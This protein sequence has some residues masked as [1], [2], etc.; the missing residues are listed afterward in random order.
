MNPLQMFL[1][2][3]WVG[4]VVIVILT[5][6][7]IYS[8]AVMID[9]FRSYRAA[10]DE[11]LQFLPLF[12]KNLRDSNFQGALDAARKY[13]PA[14]QNGRPVAIYFTIRVDFRLR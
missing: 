11:S 2:A 1:D 5:G 9:K 7:S 8:I 12:V 10:R 6:L 13:K 3:S 4:K 14:L